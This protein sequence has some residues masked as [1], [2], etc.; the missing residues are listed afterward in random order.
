MVIFVSDC[1]P[2]VFFQTLETKP[3]LK[4]FTKFKL[5]V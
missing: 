4:K 1:N 3:A 5:D 2:S